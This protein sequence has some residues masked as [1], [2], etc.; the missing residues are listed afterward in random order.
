MFQYSN[1]FYLL[2]IS[3]YK[4]NCIRYSSTIILNT[5]KTRLTRFYDK[6]SAWTSSLVLLDLLEVMLQLLKI[7]SKGKFI[8]IVKSLNLYQMINFRSAHVTVLIEENSHFLKFSNPQNFLIFLKDSCS[9]IFP[10]IL[11]W[12]NSIKQNLS[13]FHNIVIW[14]MLIVTAC[15]QAIKWTAC[16]M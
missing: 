2:I 14:L 5:Y 13:S 3:K 6:E 16:K 12:R 15:W 7:Y 1:A 10:V 9:K 11:K 8:K 4:C